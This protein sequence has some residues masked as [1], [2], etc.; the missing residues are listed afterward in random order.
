M[1]KRSA[2]LVLLVIC[3]AAVPILASA[4]TEAEWQAECRY[5]TTTTATIYDYA[6][7]ESVD[8]NGNA[9]GTFIAV[10]SLP[11]GTYIKVGAA[12]GDKRRMSYLKDGGV[13]TGYIDPG[14]YQSVTNSADGTVSKPGRPAAPW[15]VTYDGAPAV[16]KAL[17]TVH[18]AIIVDRETVVVPTSEISWETEAEEKQ[19][20]ACVN[21]KSLVSISM[22][23]AMDTKSEIIEKIPL[24]T[25]LL[26][27]KVGRKYT[28]IY[29]NGQVG[30]VLNKY[31]NYYP[32]GTEAET[33]VLSYNGHTNGKATIRIRFSSSKKS[34][35]IAELPTG[36]RVDVIEVKKKW[37]RVEVNGLRGFVMNDFLQTPAN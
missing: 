20:L 11:A 33:K 1:G 16:I 26:V 32:I 36:T 14:T 4:I 12:R 34:R 21:K 17:G 23:E 7:G 35:M 22:R 25:M 13:L 31:L 27:Q 18:T 37:S 8:E 3:L 28:R 2:L 30:Y 9:E 6:Y 19:M 5:I 29:Y 24:G 15:T 10:T